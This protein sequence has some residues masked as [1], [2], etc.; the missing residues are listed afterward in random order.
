LIPIWET[1]TIGNLG[2][3]L[4]QLEENGKYSLVNQDVSGFGIE[5]KVMDESIKTEDTQLLCRRFTTF[6]KQFVK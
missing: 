6:E 5:E 1:E 2:S 4:L 3:V